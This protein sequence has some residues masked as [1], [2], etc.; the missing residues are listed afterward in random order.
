MSYPLHNKTK[1]FFWL[2]IKLAIVIGCGVVIYSKLQENDQLQLTVFHQNLIAN[3]V[4]ST[5]NTVFL[6]IFSFLNHFFEI[7]K[8]EALV[9][10]YTKISRKTAAIQCLASLTASLMTPN[11]IGEYGAKALYFDHSLRKQIV[12]L[13]L[14][15]NFYQMAMTLIFGG[16]GFGYFVYHNRLSI[17]YD[18]IFRVLLLGVFVIAMLYYG[19]KHFKYGAYSFKKVNRFIKKIPYSLHLKIA[20]LSFL[21]FT[22]FSHLFYF[23]LLIFKV[24]I[25]YFDGISAIAS[26][27]MIASILPMLSLFDVVLKGTVALWVFH[28]FKVDPIVI[29]CITTLMWILNF[30]FPALLGSYFVLIFKPK[31]AK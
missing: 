31:I 30:V 13:N 22:V 25:S 24:D 6:L 7:L 19:A 23:L 28:F 18:G 1:Q 12:G 14:V 3:N 2:A 26:M 5:K 10:F 29:L 4:F 27:Y 20:L 15:G 17:V 8:W 16:I 11:R 9:S 21:R